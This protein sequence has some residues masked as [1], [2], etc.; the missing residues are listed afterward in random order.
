[1]NDK[2]EK[3]VDIIKE[4]ITKTDFNDEKRLKE[5]LEETKSRLNKTIIQSGNIAGR[6]RAVSDYSADYYI[7]EQ[8]SGI[9]F[10][11]FLEDI[12]EH[13][14]SRKDEVIQKLSDT[15]KYIFRKDNM[16]INYAGGQRK[17]RKRKNVS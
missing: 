14:D 2:L 4:V 11:K 1:M 17:L 16:I 13:Y 6:M 10:Y 5:I 9:A 8:I 3:A 7:R 15:K 12:L